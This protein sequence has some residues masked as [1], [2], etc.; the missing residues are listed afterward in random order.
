MGIIL[1]AA[2]SRSE[3]C[4]RVWLKYGPVELLELAVGHVDL[5]PGLRPA[6][7]PTTTG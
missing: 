3:S 6:A 1:L 5:G 2:C 4:N 7:T